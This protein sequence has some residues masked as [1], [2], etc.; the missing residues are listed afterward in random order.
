MMNLSTEYLGLK[1]RS[2]LVVGASPFCDDTSV[3]RRL[4]DSGAGALVMR[5]LFAEQFEPPPVIPPP[6]PISPTEATA[7]YP[8]FADYQLSADEYL[9]Q[10]AS[11]RRNLGI[12]VI[13]SLGGSW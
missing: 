7:A 2:P 9:R 6:D 12:P 11:L 10:I 3:A 8:E 1:L 4:E 13:A 5:S